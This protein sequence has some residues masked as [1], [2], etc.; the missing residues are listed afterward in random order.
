VLEGSLPT[1]EA[2]GIAAPILFLAARVISGVSLGGEYTG[3]FIM[4]FE[5]ARSD[6]RAVTTSLANVMAGTGIL[7]ASGLMAVLV[8]TL[9]DAAMQAWGWRI[10]FYVGAAIGVVALLIR[11]RVQETP[12]FERLR[13]QAEISEQP[14][15]EA[16]REQPTGI[17]VSFA[18]SSYNALSY[19][20]VVAFV[21]TYLQAY[22]GM[23]HI[24]AFIITTAASFLNIV[25]IPIPGLISD[26]VGRKPVL[27][28]AT[29]V[30]AVFGYPLFLMLSSGN[31]V[32]TLAAA[33]L[34]VLPAACFMSPAITTAVEHLPTRVRYSGFALGYN[35]GA[36]IF[37]GTTPLL[38]AWL[39]HI[40][41]NL[42]APSLYLI[43]AS[44]VMLAV[45]WRLRETYRAEVE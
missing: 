37:G 44:L 28:A 13:S 14:M 39:I 24:S 19:Y 12:L 3:T 41:G 42:T 22:V 9:P 23:P 5:T 33:L 32:L 45:V 15:S 17:A 38:A 21:A 18:M 11:L 27:I 25:F 2:I 26:R 4:L 20:L 40:T 29:L 7:L 31:F 16:I 35:A 34:F 30:F 1:Y 36:A 8:A 6:R 10:P 43:A